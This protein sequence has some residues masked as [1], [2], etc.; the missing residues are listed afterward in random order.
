[1]KLSPDINEDIIRLTAHS[2]KNG[3]EAGSSGFNYSEITVESGNPSQNNQPY[4]NQLFEI[5]PSASS[6]RDM[7]TTFAGTCFRSPNWSNKVMYSTYAIGTARG[8][9]QVSIRKQN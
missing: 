2:D 9:E 5:H 7:I 4:I 8:D 6:N 3:T 1:M